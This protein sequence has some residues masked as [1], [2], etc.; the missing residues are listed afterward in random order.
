[1]AIIWG[2]GACGG[3]ADEPVAFAHLGLTFA[4]P[5]VLELPAPLTSMPSAGLGRASAQAVTS[6]G[7]P[8]HDA[9]EPRPKPVSP[10]ARARAAEAM[11][12]PYHVE[13]RASRPRG[14]RLEIHIDRRPQQPRAAL[15]LARGVRHGASLAIAEVATERI[16]GRS[17]QR[18]RFSH[19]TEEGLAA[20]VEYAA[21]AGPYLYRVTAYG[22]AGPA[23]A[24]AERVAP[25]LRLHGAPDPALEAQPPPAVVPGAVQRAAGAVVA[26]VAANL[27]HAAGGPTTLTPSAMGS[28][29]VVD[30]EGRV[31]TSLHT[32]HDEGRDALHDLFLIGH[33][34]AAGG[35]VFVCA[36][37]PGHANIERALD[38][39][40][41]RCELDMSGEA[42]APSGWLALAPATTPVAA[43]PPAAG[44][45]L[46][47]LGYAEADDGA[48][49]ARAGSAMGPSQPGAGL[50]Q[51]FAVDVAIT[52][53]M[54]GGA[55]VDERGAL[56]G[57]VQG[58]RE[59]F[60]AS[61]AGIRGAGRI[62]LVRSAQ[63]ARRLIEGR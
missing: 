27:E 11:L 15:A 46:W 61:S 40:L 30:A 31:L 53:G 3:A 24:L 20:G 48:L 22:P 1:M 28:G 60:Q 54:S 51:G 63:Q 4:H 42:L 34:H 50:E 45:R 16:E 2:A 38:L 41:L 49:R 14:L 47:V 62:G 5:A 6:V 19:R 55:V 44:T 36:G 35:L 29:V 10:A 43:A 52:P 58:F 7:G 56:V 25:T 17:W 57:V 12:V 13:L 21:L 23:T 32:L 18:T 37:R 39:A 9:V 26:V 59:R 33:E 8:T